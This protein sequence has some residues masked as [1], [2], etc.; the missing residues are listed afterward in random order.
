MENQLR[1]CAYIWKKEEELGLADRYWSLHGC[2][3]RAQPE[4]GGDEDSCIEPR[5]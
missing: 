3:E 4:D 2:V 5:P 1:T